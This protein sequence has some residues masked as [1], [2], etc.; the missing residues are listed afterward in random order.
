[1]LNNL[2][3]IFLLYVVFPFLENLPK[4]LGLKQFWI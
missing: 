4:L 2:F 3:W 1:M